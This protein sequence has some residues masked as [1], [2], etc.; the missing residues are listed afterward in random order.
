MQAKNVTPEQL[1][2]AL[3]LCNHDDHYAGN[4]EFKA[5][6]AHVGRTSRSSVSFGLSVRDCR[7]RGGR[8][9]FSRNKDGERRRIG[10]CACWHAHGHFFEALFS[11]APNAVIRASGVE[12]ITGPDSYDGNWQDRQIGSA[13]DPLYY[14]EACDCYEHDHEARG[15]F[16][17]AASN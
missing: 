10:G 17:Q 9:G 7:K 2:E 15:M 12:P 5:E 11:I 8:R 13:F 4:L 16:E 6:P 14:S 3:A 1:H